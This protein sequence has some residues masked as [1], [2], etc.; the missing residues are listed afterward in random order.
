MKIYYLANIRLPTKKA[1]GLAVMKMCEAFALQGNKVELVV[2]RRLNAETE[3]PSSYYEVEENFTITKLPTLDL[4]RFGRI[5]F[6]IQSLSFSVFALCYVVL[7]KTDVIYGRDEL[8][9]SFL[10]FFKKNVVWEAHTV[11]KKWLVTGLLRRS[12][13][14]V[15]ISGGLKEYYVSLGVPEERILVAPSGVDIDVFEEITQSKEMLRERLNLPLNKKIIA[16]IGRTKTMGEEKGVGELDTVINEVKK[17]HPEA[18]LLVVSKSEPHEVPVYMEAAD[19]LVMNYPNTEHYAK[20]M[21]PLK[22]FEYMAS[23]N[24]IV[25]T[26]LPSIREILDESTA[27]LFSPDSSAGLVEKISEVLEKYDE[28]RSKASRAEEKV[29]EFTWERRAENIIAF[30]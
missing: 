6:W 11:R 20:Y 16:Y 25:T 28:A 7:K 3:S 19:I 12:K 1:H 27:Y 18:E 22:M 14:L 4:V 13:K 23:G 26:D 30:V 5:G 2:P 24:P 10:S 9:L 15:V 17:K 29:K 8:T 21:S